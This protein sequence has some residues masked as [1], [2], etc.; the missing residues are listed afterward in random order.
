[1]CAVGD[2]SWLDDVKRK[3]VVWASAGLEKCGR[4]TRRTVKRRVDAGDNA[5][6]NEDP[7]RPLKTATARTSNKISEHCLLLTAMQP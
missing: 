2:G 4:G 1:M 7:A 3:A 5:A 6:L